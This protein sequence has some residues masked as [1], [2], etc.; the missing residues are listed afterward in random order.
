MK[1]L[2]DFGN[3]RLKWAVWE[4]GRRTFGG[5]FA[6]EDTSL[7]AA[8]SNNW[9]A[10]GEPEAILVSSVVSAALEEELAQLVSAHFDCPIEFVRSPAEAIGIRNAYAEPERLGVDRFLALAAIH[11]AT[12]RAQILL[13]CGTALTLDAL[14]KDGRHLGG[15]IAPSPALMRSALGKGTARVGEQDGELIEIATNTADAAWS[16]CLLSS[17]ALIERFRAT[18]ATR[19][20]GRVAIVGDGGGLDECL[21]LIP[22][23]ERGRDLVLHGLALWSERAGQ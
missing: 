11:A 20:G 9:T 13:S 17:V 22:E 3:T 1:L 2:I 19:I 12:P 16:G 23:I 6:H 14:S 7:A 5:V 21:R 15:L 18:V 10:L 8:L 4:N